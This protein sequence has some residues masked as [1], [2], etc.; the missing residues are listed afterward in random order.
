M[1][2]RSPHRSR[3]SSWTR[4]RAPCGDCTSGAHNAAT[5]RSRTRCPPSARCAAASTGTTTSGAP[6][7]PIIEVDMTEAAQA[8]WTTAAFAALE[9]T[10]RSVS[11]ASAVVLADYDGPSHGGGPDTGERGARRAARAAPQ[12]AERVRLPDARLVVRGG[13]CGAGDDDSGLAGVRALRGARRPS[14]VALPHRDERLPR[15]AERA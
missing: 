3:P 13:R 10:G 15:H 8:D 12:R 11:L 9:S 5:A 6:S 14:L 1:R 2:H 4:S 7:H